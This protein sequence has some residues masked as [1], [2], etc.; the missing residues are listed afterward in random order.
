MSINS[1]LEEALG[2]GVIT[3]PECGE[4]LEPDAVKCLCGWKNVLM[5]AGLI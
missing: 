2:E 5:E 4:R 3:C 1:L